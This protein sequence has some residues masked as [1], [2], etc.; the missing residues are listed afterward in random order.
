MKVPEEIRKVPRP[1]NTV[2]LDK[3]PDN[4]PYRYVVQAR[5]NNKSA[6]YERNIVLGYIVDMKFVPFVPI[7]FS[8]SFGGC[9]FAHSVS[10]DIHTDLTETFGKKT[11]DL[12]YTVGV[13]RAVKPYLRFDRLAS[14][15]A[16]S[17]IG[18]AVP[19]VDLSAGSL[20]GLF[21]GIDKTLVPDYFKKRSAFAGNAVMKD[22]DIDLVLF[23]TKKSYRVSCDSESWTVTGYDTGTRTGRPKKDG[24]E[25]ERYLSLGLIMFGQFPLSPGTD[26][27]N[28]W[29]QEFL[30]IVSLSVLIRMAKSAVD[31]GLTSEVS[32]PEIIETLNE[33][34]KDHKT[35][36][37]ELL[38]VSNWSWLP[39]DGVR[40]INSLR[41]MEEISRKRRRVP[42]RKNSRQKKE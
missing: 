33:C 42:G 22:I 36:A 17:Y 25:L 37:D 11:G 41:F 38:F 9:A 31:S 40:Y 26:E 30:D 34:C 4:Y 27:E 24:E 13:M 28:I 12:I 7:E 15:Y 21:D 20:S 8:F 16:N 18:R 1:A 23:R 5:A 32:F 14:F 19:D 35:K 6:E 29:L 2:I 10:K 39:A 3:G